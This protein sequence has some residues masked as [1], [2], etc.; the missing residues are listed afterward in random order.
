[1]PLLCAAVS[2]LGLYSIAFPV[3]LRN[4]ALAGVRP[5]LGDFGML[6]A[7]SGLQ[8]NDER[9]AALGAR[10]HALLGC[11]GFISRSMANSASMRVTASLARSAPC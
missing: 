6:L 3:L 8:L 7:Q 1:M 4:A 10:A 5:I 2:R 9:P 11:K